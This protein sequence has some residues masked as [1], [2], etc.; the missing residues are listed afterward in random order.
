MKYKKILIV[1]VCLAVAFFLFSK[2]FSCL[3]YSL[4][5][6]ELTGDIKK[7]CNVD[8]LGYKQIRNDKPYFIKEGTI[9]VFD[10]DIAI[11]IVK[12]ESIPVESLLKKIYQP[13][14]LILDILI[15]PN[16]S[17][18]S[19]IYDHL[20]IITQENNK[21]YLI[22][23]ELY[24]K[25]FIAKV[26][27]EA[28]AFTNIYYDYEIEWGDDK[29]VCQNNTSTKFFFYS[30]DGKLQES[31]KFEMQTQYAKLD[32][33]NYLYLMKDKIYSYNFD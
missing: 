13:S 4:I 24:N 1:T 7:I 12:S 3:Y 10:S 29:I 28:E 25:K 8:F 14:G 5:Y 21:N 2:L 15:N 18:N 11:N 6:E 20:F 22:I 26:L 27:T 19:Y 16:C 32:D 9:Y 31:K 17:D 30:V 23:F 33:G